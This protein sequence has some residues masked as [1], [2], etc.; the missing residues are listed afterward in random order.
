LVRMG[1]QETNA[2]E[3]QLARTERRS[4]IAESGQLW[5]ARQRACG[6]RDRLAAKPSFGLDIR[7]THCAYYNPASQRGK[8]LADRF[9][10]G[11]RL[12]PVVSNENHEHV[13]SQPIRFHAARSGLGP[14]QTRPKENGCRLNGAYA[15]RYQTTNQQ[16][17]NIAGVRNLQDILP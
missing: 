4:M 2:Q 11:Q 12:I 17:K 1:I 8:T 3:E 5:A 7:L 14:V 13:T 16:K 9:A 6:Q 10:T 15:R